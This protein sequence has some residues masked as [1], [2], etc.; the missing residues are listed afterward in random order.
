[1]PPLVVNERT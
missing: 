1:V